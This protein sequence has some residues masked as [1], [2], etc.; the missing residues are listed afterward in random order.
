MRRTI[1]V[2]D[3]DQS[4]RDS[5]RFLLER[6]GYD[7]VLAENGA[8]ALELAAASRFDAAMVDVHMPGMNGVEVCR[9]LRAQAA[10][11][12]HALAV[13][14]MTGARTAELARSAAAAGALAT[15]PK[16]FDYPE[17]F[18]RFEKQFGDGAGGP[19]TSESP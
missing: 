18:R 3:D 1:L 9:A 2:V 13:W 4:V 10:Q 11:A 5:L 19:P 12:G 6:R 14:M 17:L 15:L 7:V 16:P 8:R